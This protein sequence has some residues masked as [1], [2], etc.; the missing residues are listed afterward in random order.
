LKKIKVLVLVKGNERFYFYIS[1]ISILCKMK[2]KIIQPPY[3]EPGDKVAIISPSGV[4]EAEK[5]LKAISIIE[6]WNLKVVSGTNVLKSDGPFAGSDNDRLSDLQWAINDTSIKAVFCSRG[7]YGISRIIDR[8]NFSELRKNP[9]WFI[10]FSDITVLHLWLFKICGIMSVHGEMPLNYSNPEKSTGTQDSL[11]KILFGESYKYRWEGNNERGNSASG[12]ITG[13]NL[14]LLYSLIGTAA[15][16]DT[17]GKILFIE[18]VGEY[19]YHLDRMMTSLRLAG[20]LE[21]LAALVVGGLSKMEEGRIPWGR[22]AELTISDI[23]SCYDYPVFYGF[24][25]GH[26]SENLA[27][28]IGKKVE[29][30]TSKRVNE[31]IYSG[32]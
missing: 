21:G 9:K 4:I 24:P 16:P 10:G 26:I 6:E 22:S 20:K 25:A 11:K 28:I 2:N 14:S 17:K 7:G 3:L 19:Y 12:I 30:K 1:R 13:G 32:V 15:E 29:I 31:L 5:V 27:F 8:V 18:E 23:V